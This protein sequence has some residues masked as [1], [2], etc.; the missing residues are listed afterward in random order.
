MREHAR[1]L[2]RIRQSGLALAPPAPRD[3]H[4]AHLEAGRHQRR[5]PVR[6]ANSHFPGISVWSTSALE[7]LH[8]GYCSPCAEQCV[9][10]GCQ[11][12]SNNK[13]PAPAPAHGATAGMQQCPGRAAPG[14]DVLRHAARVRQAEQAHAD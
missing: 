7:P 4:W 1:K 6:F 5:P 14:K 13:T 11:E 9:L 2:G 3:L 12:T 8:K 10:S